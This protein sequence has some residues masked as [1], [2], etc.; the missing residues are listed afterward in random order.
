MTFPRLRKQPCQQALPPRLAS[1]CARHPSWPSRFTL[2]G[3]LAGLP[4]RL[5]FSVDCYKITTVYGSRLADRQQAKVL[6][7]EPDGRPAGLPECSPPPPITPYPHERSRREQRRRTLGLL[8]AGGR[9]AEPSK[10]PQPTAKPTA[11]S[12]CGS[13]GRGCTIRRSHQHPSYTALPPAKQVYPIPTKTSLDSSAHCCCPE[14]RT[15]MLVGLFRRHHRARRLLDVRH[16]GHRP[17]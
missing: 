5:Q 11:N 8:A 14:R 12:V 3:W 6:F 1:A 13:G 2:T 10:S 7:R 4:A 15:P 17:Y 9:P 16:S